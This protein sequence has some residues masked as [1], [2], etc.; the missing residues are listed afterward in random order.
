MN[1]GR[2]VLMT[3]PVRGSSYVEVFEVT[4]FFVRIG[5]RGQDAFSRSIPLANIEISWDDGR[6]CLELQERYL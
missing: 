1:T 4:E 6:D 2:A 5:K 3:G